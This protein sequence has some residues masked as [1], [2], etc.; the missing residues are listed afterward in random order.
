MGLVMLSSRRTG[1]AAKRLASKLRTARPRGWRSV[2]AVAAIGVAV[3][4]GMT[5]LAATPSSAHTTGTPI[6]AAA[7]ARLR[8]L[9]SRTARFDGDAHP[10]SISAVATTFG[11][12]MLTL[13]PGDSVPGMTR[14]PAYLVVMKG[15]FTL[16]DASVP[17][18]ARQ[19]S[20][21]YLAIAIDPSTLRPIAVN[22]RNQPA[23]VTLR[24]YGP[25]ANLLQRR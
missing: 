22:L 17:P 7:A 14:Q 13:A 3:T 11:A 12:A 1:K 6:P 4:T 18:G 21:R 20:G 10:S 25:V 8:I 19:P 9:M 23:T 2:G 15:N 5:C 24:S 16:K